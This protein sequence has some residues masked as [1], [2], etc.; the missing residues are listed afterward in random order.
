M[1]RIFLSVTSFVALKFLN[2]SNAREVFSHFIYLLIIQFYIFIVRI[3]LLEYYMLES[4]CQPNV[5]VEL[6]LFTFESSIDTQLMVS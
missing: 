5:S 6:Y 1:S 4:S 3:L 2:L